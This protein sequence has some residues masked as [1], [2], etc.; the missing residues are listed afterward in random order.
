[1]R[2]QR[3]LTAL[4]LWALLCPTVGLAQETQDQAQLKETALPQILARIETIE[5]VAIRA[6]V[7]YKVA[8]A[9]K[10]DGRALELL[11]KGVAEVTR[12]LDAIDRPNETRRQELGAILSQLF[13]RLASYQEEWKKLMGDEKLIALVNSSGDFWADVANTLA[14]QAKAEGNPLPNLPATARVSFR[15]VK[16]NTLFKLATLRERYNQR[17][18]ADLLFRAGVMDA[19]TPTTNVEALSIASNYLFSATG[20]QAFIAYKVGTSMIRD[21]G[22][23]VREGTPPALITFFLEAM[24]RGFSR[25]HD[26]P[27]EK[28]T[29][30]VVMQIL[31]AR[32]QE[33]LS[34][35]RATAYNHQL[36]SLMSYYNPAVHGD[37]AKF[38]K[39]AEDKAKTALDDID[40]LPEA[41]R[42]NRYAGQALRAWWK[43]DFPGAEA[44][45]QKI[46][47]L[48][49]RGALLNIFKFTQGS[50][51]I[52]DGKLAEAEAIAKDLSGLELAL[53]WAHLAH[54]HAKAGNLQQAQEAVAAARKNTEAIPGFDGAQVNLVLMGIMGPVDTSLAQ[55][56][57][58]HTIK[59]FN[60]LAAE[61]AQAKEALTQRVGF[62]RAVKNKNKVVL[63]TVLP[64]LPDVKTDWT[65]IEPLYRNDPAGVLYQITHDIKH[66]AT[67]GAALI[68]L[69]QI[70]VEQPTTSPRPQP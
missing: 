40:K 49:V 52:K 34:P 27:V 58:P 14:E 33:F 29:H 25:P 13:S 3:I 28:G 9:L 42:D 51:Y 66:E 64:T 44:L 32:A 24:M 22:G 59:S 69:V 35:E 63:Y 10:K 65:V 6:I 45:A 16:D 19:I 38:G 7:R 70:I 12:E 30:Y 41:E 56:I 62:E 36:Q 15:N 37:L 47:N 17:E 48:E 68:A 26:N 53:F 4:L 23:P 50:T 43:K 46:A 18:A 8:D 39:S 31:S 54:G 60:R 55:N 11:T 67:L 5:N 20:T 1:M 2:L 61:D 21:V 57:L